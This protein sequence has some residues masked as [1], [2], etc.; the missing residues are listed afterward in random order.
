VGGGY[1]GASPLAKAG[2][3]LFRRAVG[4]VVDADAA[5]G[6]ERLSAVRGEPAAVTELFTSDRAIECQW[7]QSLPV[8][9]EPS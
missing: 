1:A 2:G 9:V 5:A 3:N 4:A 6:N 7:R 8:A